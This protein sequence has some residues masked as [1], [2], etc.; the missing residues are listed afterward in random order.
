MRVLVV[1]SGAREHAIAW[2]LA[3]SP[4]VEAIYCAPGNGGTAMIAQNLDMGITTE[5]E[6]DQL[7]GWAFNNRI[8][9]VII[10]PEAPLM[11]G[12]ADTMMVFGVRVCGPT[13]AAA[14]LEWSKVWARNFMRKQGT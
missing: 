13:K 14:R 10:G 1:G 11:H 5:P 4:A 9:L 8:D 12:L 2:K 7:A 6:C 3:L